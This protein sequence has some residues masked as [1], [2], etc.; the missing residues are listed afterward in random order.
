MYKNIHSGVRLTSATNNAKTFPDHSGPAYT[1]E[2]E[3][4]QSHWCA[5]QSV[6][7]QQ[8]S[9]EVQ[10]KILIC[11]YNLNNYIPELQKMSKYYRHDQQFYCPH[12][13]NKVYVVI[14]IVMWFMA[15][16]L[17]I[18]PTFSNVKIICFQTCHEIYNLQVKSSRVL[19][20]C[21]II[22]LRSETFLCWFA[23]NVL[24]FIF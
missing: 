19:I 16:G 14:K 12:S 17:L 24:T 18:P 15:Q 3:G 9:A 11:F 7:H 10:I 1:T 23:F 13:E 2:R 5:F 4:T 6:K 22:S 21:Y 8:K 20:I